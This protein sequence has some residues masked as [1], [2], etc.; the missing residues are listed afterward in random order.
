MSS[1][2]GNYGYNIGLEFTQCYEKYFKLRECEL[3]DLIDKLKMTN[4]QI[5]LISDVMNK[6][7]HAK[8]KDK[9]A[10]LNTDETAKKYAYLIHLRNASVFADKIH[11][12]QEDIT[13]DKKFEQ[14]VN[15]LREEG[16]SDSEIHLGT[17]LDKVHPGNIHIDLLSE[18]QID[19]VIQGLDAETKILTA[20]LNE[21]MMKINNKYEDRSQMTEHARQVLKESD[22]HIKSIIHRTKAGG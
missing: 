7:S 2:V 1:S 14:I 9:Q 21:C 10:D 20:D 16:L 11:G 3:H 6:L 8:Q 19:T 18:E 13:L 17:I 12:I 5:K 4:I 22:E 15:Q